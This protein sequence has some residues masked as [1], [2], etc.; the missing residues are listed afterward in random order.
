MPA[1]G[2]ESDWPEALP[3]GD[4]RHLF[5]A[6][7]V[8]LLTAH[9][10]D[11]VIGAGGQYAAMGRLGLVHLTDGA[12]SHKTAWKRGWLSRGRYAAGRLEESLRAA[13][14]SGVATSATLLGARDGD[15]SRSLLAT[16]ERLVR[17]LGHSRPDLVLTH[18]YEGGHP[19]HDAAAFVARA[20][21]GLVPGIPLWEMTGYHAAAAS[22]APVIAGSVGGVAIE[23]GRFLVP[24]APAG[25]PPEVAISLDAQASRLKQRMLDCFA[26]Q[27]HVLASIGPDLAAE[28]FR[29]APD[30]DFCV[31]P[32]AGQLLY[33]AQEWV[34]CDGAQWRALAQEA[35]EALA[36]A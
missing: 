32:H 17:V 35:S 26:S 24:A 16:V 9:P 25:R 34:H 8:M 36:K 6:R 12:S 2:A 30:Y 13:S 7:H 15:A 27:R 28:R 22:E 23:T 21:C 11:E 18:A 3:D 20:A 19:D 33:E 4:G 29:P 14:L 1:S 5:A 31:P 10:D